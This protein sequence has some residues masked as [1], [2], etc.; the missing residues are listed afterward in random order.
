MSISKYFTSN[1]T[2][3]GKMMTQSFSLETSG[4]SSKAYESIVETIK[5]AEKA[6]R[7]TY[8]EKDKMKITKYTSLYGIAH[9][10]K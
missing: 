10:V 9:A 7:I 2:S 5:P 8:K 1:K 3:T 4:V 6:K